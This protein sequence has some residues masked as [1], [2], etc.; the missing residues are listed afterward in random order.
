MLA[1]EQ[2]TESMFDHFDHDHSGLLEEPELREL[3]SGERG[4]GA[5]RGGYPQGSLIIAP[6]WF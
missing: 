5:E 2:Y 6:G 3:I 1:A 4:R